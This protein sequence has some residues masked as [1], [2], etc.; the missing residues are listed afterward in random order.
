MRE[1]TLCDKEFEGK[2]GCG[3]EE[4]QSFNQPSC[5]LIYHA[6]NRSIKH[7]SQSNQI[8]SDQIKSNQISQPINHLLRLTVETICWEQLAKSAVE[9]ICWH[10]L[11]N[12][13]RYYLLKSVGKNIC[14][15]QLL[16]WS[17][18]AIC[19]EC[20]DRLLNLKSIVEIICW[21]LLLRSVGEIFCS[22]V[23]I[24]C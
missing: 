23:E 15:T 11:L 14:W 9:I 6:I 20:W 3:W 12:N 13:C 19:W 16:E 7:A 17:V 18:E 21:D 8:K 10:Y 22:N 4:E 1:A 24:I 2:G 5:Q